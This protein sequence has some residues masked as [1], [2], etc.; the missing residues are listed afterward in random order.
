MFPPGHYYSSKNAH[1]NR[2]LTRFYN[3]AWCDLVA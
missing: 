2:G 3:P 1:V